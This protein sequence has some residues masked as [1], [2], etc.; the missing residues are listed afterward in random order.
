MVKVVHEEPNTLICDSCRTKFTYDQ[1]DVHIGLF[2]CKVVNCPKC[3]EETFVTGE[4]I[5]PPHFPETFYH[6]GQRNDCMKLNNEEI[7]KGIDEVRKELILGSEYSY[8]GT[9]DTM[10]IGF[11]NNDERTFIVAREYYEDDEFLKE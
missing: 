2:G 3:G 1:E 5:K 7:Q 8:Y 11:Q 10:V 6:C 9:G 4:R